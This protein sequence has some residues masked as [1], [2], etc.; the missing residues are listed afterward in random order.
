[1]K[2]KLNYLVV[3]L[4]VIASLV[5][6]GCKSKAQKEFEDTMYDCEMNKAYIYYKSGAINYAEYEALKRDINEQYK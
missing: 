6:F 2:K 1:M 3:G 4:L 5:S